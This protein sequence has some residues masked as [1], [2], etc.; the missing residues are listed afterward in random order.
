LIQHLISSLPTASLHPVEMA[1]KGFNLLCRQQ[2]WAAERLAA[3]AG[4]T[5]RIS[6][7]GFQAS[8]T[9][10]SE[11]GLAKADDAVVPNVTLHIVPE[12]MGVGVVD[13]R[14]TG[15]A[16]V[17]FINIEGEAGLA[18]VVSDLSRDLRPD[19]EDA[20]SRW[21][22]DVAA[23]R[24]VSAA[25]SLFRALRQATE[26]FGENVAEYLAYEDPQIVPRPDLAQ[27]A[28][29]QQELTQQIERLSI[30]S[31]QLCKRVDHLARAS[32]PRR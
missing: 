22:G 2:P 9:I 25:G 30:R 27:L 32:E 26:R 24:L 12:R 14:Q 28:A 16:V 29:Q 7:G 8:F 11:G 5:I 31:D 10:S 17:D 15:Q 20:L 13:S 6:L 1:A 4:K 3:H 18:Q 23:V 21:V 19:P